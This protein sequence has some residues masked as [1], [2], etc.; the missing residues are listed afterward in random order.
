VADRAATRPESPP[1]ASLGRRGQGRARSEIIDYYDATSI[2][3]LSPQG[4]IAPR[5]SGAMLSALFRQGRASS[6]RGGGRR[7]SAGGDEAVAWGAPPTRT[8]RKDRASGAAPPGSSRESRSGA[9]PSNLRAGSSGGRI[10][11]GGREAAP[12]GF[13]RVPRVTRTRDGH[14][15][16]GRENRRPGKN[17]LP[18]PAKIAA[19]PQ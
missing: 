3:A 16:L 17:Y 13:V 4:P 11:L 14:V 1:S 6:T 18:H 19:A 8:S 10:G 7:A 5:I 2:R 9:E 15:V 12:V